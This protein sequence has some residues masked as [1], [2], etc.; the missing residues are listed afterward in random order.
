MEDPELVAL[1]ELITEMLSNC[2]DQD[3][4]NLI[5]KLFVHETV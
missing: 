4:L 3:L 2:T 5:Y 1:R